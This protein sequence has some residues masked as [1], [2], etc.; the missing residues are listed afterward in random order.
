MTYLKCYPLE[1]APQ[2]EIFLEAIGQERKSGEG[3]KVEGRLMWKGGK[4][5]QRRKKSRG[6]EPDENWWEGEVGGR[7]RRILYSC[8]I[9]CANF[10]VILVRTTV[11]LMESPPPF[12]TCRTQRASGHTT[13]GKMGPLL[14]LLYSLA[15]HPSSHN[16]LS[17]QWV[18]KYGY[19]S[20]YSQP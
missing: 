7:R 1:R 16:S 13:T 20:M 8:S 11:E 14:K 9:C 5:W 12:F 3:R 4:E 10:S 15:M 18:W 6:K 17:L 19:K 2:H